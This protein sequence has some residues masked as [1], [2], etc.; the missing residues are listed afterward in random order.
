MPSYFLLFGAPS[1][2]QGHNIY[3]K[4]FVQLRVFVYHS[5]SEVIA[6]LVLLSMSFQGLCKQQAVAP[7]ASFLQPV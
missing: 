7:K 2:R 4:G 6:T 1:D 5:D 3:L